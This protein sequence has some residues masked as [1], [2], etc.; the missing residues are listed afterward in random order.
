M[1]VLSYSPLHEQ[2][3]LGTCLKYE[4]VLLKFI[5]RADI[6][7][8]V[9]DH[10][11]IWAGLQ[12]MAERK[13]KYTPGTLETILPKAGWQGRS[14]LEKL[15][16]LAEKENVEYHLKRMVWDQTRLVLFS[17]NV[18]KLT[19][20][21]KDTKEEPE[22]AR[23][24]A[25]D[26]LGTLAVTRDDDP[27]VKNKPLIAKV[28]A[29]YRARRIAKPNFRTSGYKSLDLNL[30]EGF[31][32]RRVSVIAATPS[33]GK[34]TFML[35]LAKKQAMENDIKVGILAW[36]GGIQSSIDT[37]CASHLGIPLSKFLK[38]ANRINDE[39]QKNIDDFVANL[40]GTENLL[41]LKPPPNRFMRGSP[42]DVTARVLDWAEDQFSRWGRDVIYWDLFLKKIPASTPDQVTQALNRI[43]SMNEDDGGSVNSH[44]CLLHQ[45]NL[46]ILEERNDKRPTRDVLK[47]TGAWVENPDLVLTLYRPAIHEPELE[48]NV[49]E[50]TCWKQRRG[51]WPWRM[52][53]DWNGPT[54]NI[55][56]GQR[57]NMRVPHEVTP[58]VRKNFGRGKV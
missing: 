14:Y 6:E 3:V 18:A 35:N 45:I 28:Q 52:T 47:G 50:V 9:E 32:D 31:A 29:T 12:T 26:I 5:G 39:E 7:F 10:K 16:K 36:E 13:L 2:I 53:M 40:L 17:G 11:L 15:Y 20:V 25:E 41:F 4:E 27:I 8:G 22:T 33:T 44:I 49:L 1:P 51:Q 37:M 24:L 42:W 46:K 34:T 23:K 55:S 38:F 48:D 58:K 56:G 30:D 21:L 43:Q 57:M 19:N 54:V